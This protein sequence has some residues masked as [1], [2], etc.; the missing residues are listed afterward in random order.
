MPLCRSINQS[1]R[2]RQKNLNQEV[3]S[4]RANDVAA[5]SSIIVSTRGGERMVRVKLGKLINKLTLRVNQQLSAQH[6]RQR[7]S[8]LLMSSGAAARRVDAL[9]LVIVLRKDSIVD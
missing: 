4:T 6:Q 1:A 5:T 2:T 7:S 9:F 8:P 3:I